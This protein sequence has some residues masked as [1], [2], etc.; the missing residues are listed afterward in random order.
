MK[1]SELRQIIIEEAK[2]AL[3]E[4]STLSDAAN[5][6]AKK[7]KDISKQ[8]SILRQQLALLQNQ[9]EELVAA[10]SNDSINKIESALKS[11]FPNA[12]IYNNVSGIRVLL[13]RSDHIATGYIR[14]LISDLEQKTGLPKASIK[15]T[16]T[17]NG[18]NY[19]I[20]S[21]NVVLTQGYK[22][23]ELN[24]PNWNDAMRK[25]K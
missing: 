13:K 6:L 17:V 11:K 7:G 23:T 5:N 3:N 22:K 24:F 25:A 2:K 10:A 9:Y 20:E 19:E 12:K 8:I 4:A 16:D 1:V 21:F 15:I 14:T 18:S